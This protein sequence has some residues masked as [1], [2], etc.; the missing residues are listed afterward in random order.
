MLMKIT[1][2]H[3]KKLAALVAA[4]T[5]LIG[6]SGCASI[7]S[8]S[9]YPVQ[10]TS[11]PEGA[12]FAIKNSSGRT[13]QKGMTPSVVMLDSGAGFFRGETYRVKFEKEGYETSVAEIDTSLDPWYIG[14][15]LFGGLIGL[16]IVDPATG[17]MWKLPDSKCEY[18][19]LE[20]SE[21]EL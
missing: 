11:S 3:S 15:I 16:L 10:I 5:L 12:T 21:E 18:L 1:H 2:H 19:Y 13:I 6:G 4:G 20:N 14:N 7:V 9:A 8:K 17:A